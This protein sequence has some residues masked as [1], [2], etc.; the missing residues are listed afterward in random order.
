MSRTRYEVEG[1]RVQPAQ[2]QSGQRRGVLF[3]VSGPSGVGKTS[4]CQHIV[5]AMPDVRQSVSY[6][7][8]PPRSHECDG[9]EYHFVSQAAFEQRM[10]TG[11]FLEWARVHGHLYGTSRQQIAALTQAGVDVLLAIDVQ[12]AAQLRVAAVDAVFIFVTPPSWATLSTRL[13]QRAS[14]TREIQ[15]Q[16]LAVAHQELTHYTEYD[17]IVINDQLAPTIATLQAVIVAERHR[18][19]RF[20]TVAVAHLLTD[21]PAILA[22]APAVSRG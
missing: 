9:R 3:V 13:D 4:L 22:S 20:G 19:E 10:R 8:R 2:E 7:T 16:R 21:A 15:A 1:V 6:T 5:A 18:V 12:G 11:D 14:E 17:Y